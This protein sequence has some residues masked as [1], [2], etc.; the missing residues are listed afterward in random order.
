MSLPNTSGKHAGEAVIDPATVIEERRKSGLP[1][2]P[3]VESV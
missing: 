2:L 3:T 1:S